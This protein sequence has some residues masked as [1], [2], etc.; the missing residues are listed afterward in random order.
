MRKRNKGRSL[1]CAY[2]RAIALLI[3]IHAI[4]LPIPKDRSPLPYSQK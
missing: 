3:P 4:A 2:K 1:I